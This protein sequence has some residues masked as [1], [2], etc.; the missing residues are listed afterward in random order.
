MCW[1]SLS[2]LKGE[3]RMR[4]SGKNV[5]VVSVRVLDGRWEVNGGCWWEEGISIAGTQD[6][7]S[8]LVQLKSF[9]F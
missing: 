9:S 1:G 2:L 7:V 4:G 3:K 5:C 6:A 8:P